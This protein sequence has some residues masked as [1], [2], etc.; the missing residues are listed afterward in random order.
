MNKNIN[1][2]FTQTKQQKKKCIP[3]INAINECLE[4]SEEYKEWESLDKT[5]PSAFDPAVVFGA[6]YTC[7]KEIYNKQCVEDI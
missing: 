6:F 3:D 5:K 4:A 1:H 2:L 7:S